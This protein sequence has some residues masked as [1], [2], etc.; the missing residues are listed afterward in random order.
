M[1]TIRL[2]DVTLTKRRLNTKD[3]RNLEEN[4][5]QWQKI[6]CGFELFRPCTKSKQMGNGQSV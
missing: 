5:K 3:A 1:K 4:G 6:E 2:V